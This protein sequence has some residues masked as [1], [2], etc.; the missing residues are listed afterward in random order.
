MVDQTGRLL[1]SH[2]DSF[3]RIGQDTAQS[4]LTK[5]VLARPDG[6]AELTGQDGIPRLIGFARLLPE[7][8]DSPT[9]YVGIPQDEAYAKAEAMRTKLPARYA[10]RNRQCLTRHLERGFQRA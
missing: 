6:N 3:G 7:L 8:P 9:V 10:C 1:W 4:P 2:P 5:A